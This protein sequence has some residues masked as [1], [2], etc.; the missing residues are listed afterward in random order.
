MK[1]NVIT[2]MILMLVASLSVQA[3]PYDLDKYPWLDKSFSYYDES[4]HTFR[5][6]STAELQ[7]ATSSDDADIKYRQAVSTQAGTVGETY[8]S[9]HIDEIPA[10]VSNQ[11]RNTDHIYTVLGAYVGSASCYDSLPKGVYVLN[12]VK[13]I[14]K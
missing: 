1:R 3:I 13:Y 9:T 11:L 5:T 14:K 2:L 7:I 4:T 6:E 12:G 8:I 10:V